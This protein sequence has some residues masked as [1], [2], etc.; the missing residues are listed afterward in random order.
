ML[1]PSQL[2]CLVSWS[3]LF[4]VVE[5]KPLKSRDI[6]KNST[7]WRSI[8]NTPAKKSVVAGEEWYEFRQ[9]V[10]KDM[11]KISSAL[12]YLAE[13]QDIAEVCEVQQDMK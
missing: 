7:E 12:H 1:D 11:M 10:Q 8:Q 6:N 4:Y 9:A 5:V 2:L 13:I 3:S